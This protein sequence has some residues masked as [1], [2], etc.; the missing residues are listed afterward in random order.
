M[1]NYIFSISYDRRGNAVGEYLAPFPPLT[2]SGVPFFADG[3][4]IS[5]QYNFVCHGIAQGN[6]TSAVS[7]SQVFATP[8]FTNGEG[9]FP[10]GT[11]TYDLNSGNNFTVVLGNTTSQTEKWR[12]QGTFESTFTNPGV[13][14]KW[15]PECD[16]GSGNG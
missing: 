15:D 12:F 16:V 8:A 4:S 1:V 3:D 11:Y 6:D 9:P 5:Y 10:G 2:D 13:V 14:V 7:N